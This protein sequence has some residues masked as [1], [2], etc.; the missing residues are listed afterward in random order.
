VTNYN[1]IAV[2]WCIWGTRWTC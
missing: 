1:S 2:G